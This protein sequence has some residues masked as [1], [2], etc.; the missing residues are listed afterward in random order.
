MTKY[1]RFCKG[2]SKRSIVHRPALNKHTLIVNFLAGALCLLLA[3]ASATP[4][5]TIEARIHIVSLAPP[6]ISVEGMSDRPTTAWSFR[7]TYAGLLGLGDRKSQR[8]N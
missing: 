7:T 1:K 3:S 8:L 6:R 5:Q 2:L 4:A